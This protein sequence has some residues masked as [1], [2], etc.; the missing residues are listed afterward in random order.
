MYQLHNLLYVYGTS[1]VILHA[2]GSNRVIIY[3]YIYICVWFEQG[4]C[5]S[6]RF[7]EKV[8]AHLSHRTY[9]ICIL[10]VKPDAIL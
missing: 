1:R 9:L 10:I 3:I 7:R 2:L 5:S 8:I 4:H 6:A